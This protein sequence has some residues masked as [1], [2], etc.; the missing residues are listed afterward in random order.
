MRPGEAFVTRALYAALLD[1]CASA[2]RTPFTEAEQ[3]AA[4]PADVD[5]TRYCADGPASA[6]QRERFAVTQ[7]GRPLIYLARSGGGG[8]AYGAGVL[9]GW[10][11]SGARPEFTMVSRI[12]T[13][14]LIA[15]F[16]FLG[17]AYDATSR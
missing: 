16:A 9:N 2:P 12:S 3:I 8:G 15:P 13:G 5:T 7:L 17:P 4:L 10:T 6:F 1:G 14:A 11:Q